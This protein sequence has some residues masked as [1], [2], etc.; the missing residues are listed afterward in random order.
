MKVIKIG[1]GCLKGN[2]TIARIVDL[3][4]K[5]GRG[6][7][8]VVSALNGVTDSLIDGM[9]D[10]LKDEENVPKIM[11]RIKS[12]H[13]GAARDL[14]Q[15]GKHQKAYTGELNKTAGELERLFYGLCFTRENTPR[16]TDLITSYG[17]RFSA[18]LLTAVLGSRGIQT[19]CLMPHRIGMATDGKFGDATADMAKTEKNLEKHLKPVLNDKTIVFIPGFYGIGKSGEITTFGRGGSD[20]SAA[21]V[22]AAAGAEILEIWKDVDGF[23]SADPKMVGNTRLIPFL[24]YDEA[25]ELAYFGAKILHARSVEPVRK[26]KLNI[27]IKNTLNPDAEGSLITARGR[28]EKSVIKSVA[29]T[30]DIG[31][32]KVY[33]AGVGARQGILAIVAGCLAETGINIKSVVTS[34]TCISLLLAKNDLEPGR[35]ALM[36]IRPRPF[37][38]V[39]IVDDMAL[40]SIVGDGLLNRKG[41]AAKC[42]SAVA[43]KNVNVEMISFGPS[44]SALYF[45]TKTSRLETAVKAIHETFFSKN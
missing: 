22:A 13:A 20:Y 37:R 45:L 12:K 16:I 34:Q 15:N 29:H 4:A 36:K 7:V 10:A 27:A 28:R 9:A 18:K 40:V 6:H 1:G 5:R 8:F 26:R 21:V 32:I 3:I 33:A 14:V 11:S 41:I 39:E 2:K 38:R 24:S 42:F 31:I 17:E 25:A 44:P 23:L 35:A 30:T 43:S 19:V